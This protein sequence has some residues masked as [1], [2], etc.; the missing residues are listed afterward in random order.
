LL[1]NLTLRTGVDVQ[2]SPYTIDGQVPE[3]GGPGAPFLGPG[4]ARP[5]RAFDQSKLFFQPAVYG[6]LT[7]RA[8]RLEVV[9]GVRLDYTHAT[10]RFD[11]S[12]RLTARYDLRTGPRTTLKGGSGVFYQPPGL[13][14]LTLLRYE[15]TATGRAYGVETMLRYTADDDFFGWLSYTLS[16]SERTWGPGEPSQRFYA[17]QPHVLALLGSYNLG[18][19]WELGARFRLV[20]GNLYTPCLGGI[21]SSASTSY[22]CVSGEQNSRRLETFHQLDVRVDKRWVFSSFTLGIYLDLINAYNHISQDSPDY[23]FDFSQAGTAS[24]SLPITPSLGI[25]GEF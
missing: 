20:S 9:S 24:Q 4:L 13:F 21:Y 7:T 10:R 6:E 22:I 16:R 3:E 12:P 25:R 14:E 19:G 18:K 5:S 11:V 17:D 8:K 1:P 2:L 23:S 15:N